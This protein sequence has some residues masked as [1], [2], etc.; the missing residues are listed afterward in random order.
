MSICL[1]YEYT[2][3]YL[4]KARAYQHFYHSRI[5]SA[6]FNKYLI[7]VSNNGVSAIIDNYGNIFEFIPL[8]IKNK[9]NVKIAIPKE[10]KNHTQYHN[11]I[12][13]FLILLIIISLF[14]NTKNE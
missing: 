5:R 1:L 3:D 13:P 9:K 7:R 14:V 12:Y 2:V 10:L 4:I 8:N 6:E 11:L